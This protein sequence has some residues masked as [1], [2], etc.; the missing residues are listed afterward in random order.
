MQRSEIRIKSENGRVRSKNTVSTHRNQQTRE[1]PRLIMPTRQSND[2][3]TAA[4]IAG[5]LTKVLR[6][7]SRA[8]KEEKRKKLEG[9]YAMV[10][11]VSGDT[12]SVKVHR[13]WYVLRNES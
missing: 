2:N 3:K 11:S 1:S 8:S 7:I 9:H 4:I 13:N 5:D 6:A 12:K 10:R